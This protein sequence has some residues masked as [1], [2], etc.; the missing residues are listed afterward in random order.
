M[1]LDNTLNQAFE[2]LSGRLRAELQTAAD[3]MAA[4]LKA[5]RDRLAASAQ[6]ASER[7]AGGDRTLDAVRSLGAAGSL[8]EVLDT[9]AGCAAHEASR[10]GILLVQGDRLRGWRF[11]GF[12]SGFDTA[13]AIDIAISDSGPLADAVR[14]GATI[15]GTAAPRFA[16]LPE[17]KQSVAVPIA[18]GDQA[19][20]VLYADEG[21]VPDATAIQRANQG[22]QARVEVL[23][24][25]AS[26]CLEAITAF[27]TARLVQQRAS[28]SGGGAGTA[29]DEQAETGD[30]DAAALRYARLLVSEIKLYH[31]S[32]VMAGRREKDLGTRLGTEIRRARQL[33]EQRV[34]PE[35]GRRSDYFQAELVRTLADGDAALLELA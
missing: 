16:D 28:R 23:A 8:S 27:R 35:V 24:R 2:A 33:Y 14:S 22:W 31:E 30:P 34:P 10:A 25:F 26:R 6:A 1:N 32:D 12:P 20:A 21:A 15:A 29:N 7:A 3:E 18:V 4:A 19:V 17:G 5:E 13:A 11:V 9:L